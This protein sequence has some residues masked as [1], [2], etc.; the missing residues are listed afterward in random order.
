[1]KNQRLASELEQEISLFLEAKQSLMLAVVDENGSPIA[2][3]SPFVA[4]ENSLY[5]LVSALA[6]HTAALRKAQKASVLIIDDESE[7]DTVYARRRLQYDM[8]VSTVMRN[9]KRWAI[10]GDA[11]VQRHGD[12][13]V[14]LLQL[15]DFQMFKLTPHCGRFVKGFGR[16]YELAPNSLVSDQLDHIRG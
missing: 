10:I 12:I 8:A 5:I 13:V 6:L 11:L 15:G 1:M 7:C 4:Y 16:A 14:Q 2:S 3:Y 9:D